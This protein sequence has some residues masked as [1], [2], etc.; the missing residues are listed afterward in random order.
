MNQVFVLLLVVPIVVRWS[1]FG[2]RA[3]ASIASIACVGERLYAFGG[4]SSHDSPVEAIF[5]FSLQPNPNAPGATRRKWKPLPGKLYLSDE[6]SGSAV[7][8]HGGCAMILGGS[9]S[10]DA[11]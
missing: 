8:V 5:S 2:Q 6:R 1:R 10:Y 11:V 7:V 3:P 9:A 4:F